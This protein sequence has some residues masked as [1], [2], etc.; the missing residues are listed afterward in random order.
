MHGSDAVARRNAAILALLK[1]GRTLNE[2]CTDVAFLLLQCRDVS[3]GKIKAIAAEFHRC[4]TKDRAEFNAARP[5]VEMFNDWLLW[6]WKTVLNDRVPL[7]VL[8]RVMQ[9]HLEANIGYDRRRAIRWLSRH[10][11][12]MVRAIVFLGRGLEQTE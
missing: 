9:H 11:A 2:A 12:V 8:W 10:K 4:R 7:C 6:I 1:S 3:P 5:W